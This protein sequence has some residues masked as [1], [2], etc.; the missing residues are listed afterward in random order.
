MELSHE[1]K[2]LKFSKIKILWMKQMRA[3]RIFLFSA[4]STSWS[5]PPSNKQWVWLN[6]KQIMVLVFRHYL[7]IFKDIIKEVNNWHMQ[8]SSR[9]IKRENLSALTCILPISNPKRTNPR[10]ATTMAN[11]ISP[12]KVLVRRPCPKE[13]QPTSSIKSI[14]SE[15]YG[16]F[17]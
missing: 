11:I 15:K 1:I 4:W 2:K 5:H 9:L 6:R 7:L 10:V 17:F 13:L 16:I 12:T 3:K 14:K 8:S